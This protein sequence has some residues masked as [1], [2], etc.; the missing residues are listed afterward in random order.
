MRKIRGFTLIE[1]IIS[2][3]VIGII[4]VAATPVM[5]KSM[6]AYN[7]TLDVAI[8]L[9]KLRYASERMAREIREATV[10]TFNM[11]TA[12]PQFTRDDYAGTINTIRGVSIV[13]SGEIVNFSYNNPTVTPT[14]VLTDQATALSFAYYDADGASTPDAAAVRYVE[15]NLTLA[16][17]G[18]SYTQR[19]RVALRNRNP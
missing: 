1:L 4:A 17:N 9:D 12:A 14:P 2:V 16:A 18:Q 11:N 5:V 7:A 3:V 8:T 15:I 13:R 19:T 10:G 6:D